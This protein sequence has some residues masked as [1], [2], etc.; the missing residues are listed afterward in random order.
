[1]HGRVGQGRV[2]RA[3]QGR[4]GRVPNIGALAEMAQSTGTDSVEGTVEIVP[5]IVQALRVIGDFASGLCLLRV[6]L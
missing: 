2:G 6:F 3:G 5:V 4:V 1:M